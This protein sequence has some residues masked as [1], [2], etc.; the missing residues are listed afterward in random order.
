LLK[1]YK[2]IDIRR[3]HPTRIDNNSILWINDV[4]DEELLSKWI[5]DQEPA[6]IVNDHFN[7]IEI[8]GKK[9]YCVPLWTAKEASRIV[10]ALS[11]DQL[12]QTRHTFNFMINKKQVNRFL[13]MKFVELFKLTKYD[14]T[15]SGAG[16]N[17]DLSSVLNE[18]DQLGDRS[19]LTT[20]QKS[21]IL[22]SIQIPP[23]F[24][25][26]P[27]EEKHSDSHITYCGNPWVWKHVVNLMFS[28]SATSLITESLSFQKGTLFSEKTVFAL[29][30]KTFPLWVGG[31]I[32][33]AQ[34][35]K[36]MGF[37]IFDDVIDHS[38]Q[39]YT[40]L[41]ERCYYAFERNLHILSDYDY[42]SK[43]RESMM[44]RL[45]HNQ[46]LIKNKQID[47]FCR[48]QINQW[49]EELQQAIDYRVKMWI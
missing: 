42:A 43:I 41:I 33:Q 27:G 20:Q 16:T 38:Y 24:I 49:P 36:K 17:F 19:P 10:L 47:Y 12:Y 39:H 35:F 29:L 18:L 22:S 40:T 2:L 45:E 14:Y 9:I 34:E 3:Q 32:N 37:D 8:P 5:S 7:S 26:S 21:Y 11:S 15:W 13:C 28:G 25:S 30:G 31:G 6:Y 23:K 46:Q 48:Q 44:P 1:N 4:F